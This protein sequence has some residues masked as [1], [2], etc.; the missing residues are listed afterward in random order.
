[1]RYACCEERRLRAVKAV[2]ALN[3]IEYVEVSDAD[4][5]S[6]ALRQRTLFVRLLRP[7]ATLTAANVTITGGERVPAVAVEWV[8]AATALPAGED[9]A[10]V[11]GLEDPAN[12]V[13]VRAAGRGDFSRYTLALVAGPATPGPPAGYDTLLSAVE[14]SFK[15]DCPSD[16]DCAPACDCDDEQPASPAIDYLAKDFDG[17]RRLMLDRLSLLAPGWTERNA[18]DLGVTL[19]ELLAYIG[20][21]LS[22][23]QD[24]V[25]T[26]AYLATARSRISLRRHARLV[27]YELDEGA[28]ACAWIR[29]I[30]AGGPVTLAASTVL[31]TRVPDTEHVIDPG[32]PEHRAALAAGCATFETVAAATLYDDHEELDFWTWGDDACCLPRGATSA[33]LAGAYPDLHPGDVLILAEVVGPGTAQPQDADPAKRA[34]V[35]LTSVSVSVDLA[36]GAFAAVPTSAPADVTEIAWDDADALP[37]SLCISVREHPGLVVSKAWGNIVLADHG[38]TIAGE[39]LGVVPE[40]AL[41]YAGD[42]GCG[43][44]DRD[45]PI[46]VPVRYR[47]ALARGPLTHARALAHPP[48]PGTAT[49]AAPARTAGPAIELRA[50]LD[51]VVEP[52]RAQADLLASAGDAPEFVVEVEHDGEATLRFGDGV[53]GRRPDPGTS[54]AATYRV[55][56][57]REGNVGALAIAHAV[58]LNGA[59]ARVE[60]P[61]PASGGSDPEPA[62]A[63]RRD[64]PQAFLVQQ[65]AVTADDYA[66]MAE[67]SARVQR[68]AATSR[69]TGSWQTVFVTADRAGGEPVDAAFEG[70][71]RRDLEPYRMAGY[72]L[73][74]DGPQ[75]VGLDIGLH[76]CVAPEHFRGHVRAAVLDVV[77]SGVRA[78]GEIGLLHPDRFTFGQ[79][80][81]LSPIVAAAQ[82]VPGV[83]SVTAT[84]FRRQ[85]EAAADGLDTGVLPMGRLEIGRLDNDPN[86]PEHGLLTLVI[87]GGK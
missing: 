33:T 80:V 74:V 64:A 58:T 66:R 79:P 36:G 40:P 5:P 37:F 51:G 27:D 18:A 69:W 62:E 16:F 32:G 26:E 2:G 60:N 19:V 78:G 72:D 41:T 45:D 82:A 21:E 17:F 87:G 76:V 54:F 7:D 85:R 25:A 55:G 71:V 53:H 35:R 22:Y 23:R 30:V 48:G 47:P 81:F 46:D 14:F 70:M 50:T 52:W 1:M 28:N 13:V 4:A 43:P 15:V 59:V 34:A 56:N 31:L 11:A 65:R 8:A 57:G 38:A 86:F 63:V 42:T 20:D 39:P 10:L 29:V 6:H 44:C 24:A 9:P 83:A 67:R 61:L 77:S 49:V 3:G 84:S 68:A 12:V 73:E 75:Y